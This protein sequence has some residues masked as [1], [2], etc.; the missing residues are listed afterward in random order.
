MSRAKLVL[1]TPGPVRIPPIVADYMADPPVNYHRQEGFRTMF[2]ETEK[3]VKE[4][5]GIRDLS[6]YFATMLI[7]TGTGA[8]E[9]CLQAFAPLGK[10]LI[11]RN[12]FFGA[13]WV[14][15]AVQEGFA[16]TV[17]D[18]D[19]QQ[20]VDVAQLE[21][22]LDADPSLKWVF[23]VAHE[24]RAGLVNPMVAI[25]QAAKKR[26]L[27][28]GADVVSAAYAY[29]IDIEAAGIDLA[30][31]SS[32]KAIQG[33]PGIGIVFVKLA[34]LPVLAQHKRT[35]YYFDLV[36][37]TDKQRKELQTRFAQPVALHAAL[38]AAC[39]HM[40]QVGIANHFARIQRQMKTI[41]DHLATMGLHAQLDP[42]HRSNVAVNFKL[43]AGLEYPE[44]AQR[45]EAEGY[46][47]LYGIPGDMTHFQI[48]TIGDLT[49]EHVAGICRAFDKVLG[50]ARA[51][52]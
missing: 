15:Q 30:V 13:R 43:P 3:D 4:L 18:G 26:G 19:E 5:L 7:S 10:G 28:V 29:P 35:N 1:F 16:H 23:F 11:I 39:D 38:R 44:F 34:T 37:E 27:L 20:P 36:A 12:G 45:M 21:A 49:D 22:A 41:A 48:S 9:A 8:V 52:A 33:V 14:D 50:R 51:A 31:T 24:T 32:A 25:G 47:L 6:A 40:K 17:L 2:A 46:Y 42:A